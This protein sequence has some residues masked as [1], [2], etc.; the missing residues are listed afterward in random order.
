MENG[1]WC[2]VELPPGCTPVGS[3]WVFHIKHTADS[4]IEQYKAHWWPRVSPSNLVGTLLSP[5]PPQS[6]FLLCVLS[7]HLWLQMTPN[8]TQ[9]TLPL[10]SWMETLRKRYIWSYQRAIAVFKGWFIALLPAHE[11]THGLKQGGRQ[12]YLKLSKVMKE[13]GFRKVWS[14]PCVYVWEDSI[15]EKVVV[16]TY[17]DDC[18]IIG[19]T[20]E[21]KAELQKCFKLHD[22]P[23]G[24]LVLIFSTTAPH[25][26]LPCPNASTLSICSRTL[27]WRIVHL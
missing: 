19:R 22:L 11:G 5:L 8:V 21:I 4:S 1:T 14:E 26:R 13:I 20:R 25:A 16:P 18:H 15:G 23:T 3:H 6:G 17:V 9:S 10:L 12:W 24:S 27:V 2:L 7:L